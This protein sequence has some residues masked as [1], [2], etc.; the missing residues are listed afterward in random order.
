[1]FP[2]YMHSFVLG[3]VSAALVNYLEGVFRG[4]TSIGLTTMRRFPQLE[5]RIHRKSR[6][7]DTPGKTISATFPYPGTCPIIHYEYRCGD[8]PGAPLDGGVALRYIPKDATTFD[9]Y[10]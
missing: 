1:M 7:L 8:I 3:S 4:Y 10:E 6:I 9:G 2:E 5:N